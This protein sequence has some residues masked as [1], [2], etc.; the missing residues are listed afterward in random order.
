VQPA[1]RGSSSGRSSSTAVGWA[2]ERNALARLGHAGSRMLAVDASAS[3]SAVCAAVCAAAAGD[4][5]IWDAGRAAGSAT[6]KWRL[7]AHRK[8]RCAAGDTCWCSC[9]SCQRLPVQQASS[10]STAECTWAKLCTTVTCVVPCC[11]YVPSRALWH[12]HACLGM[13]RLHLPESTR[14]LAMICHY[15]TY[16]GTA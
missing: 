13:C 15:V 11:S 12:T 9:Y 1:G 2:A 6:A 14:Q 5:C 8:V 16:P 3:A 4:C 10:L 7:V